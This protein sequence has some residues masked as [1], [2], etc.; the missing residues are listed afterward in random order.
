MPTGT[1]GGVG[2]L[3]A[4]TKGH[5]VDTKEQVEAVGKIDNSHKPQDV[6]QKEHSGQELS[7]PANIDEVTDNFETLSERVREVEKFVQHS[8]RDLRFDVDEQ[9]GDMVVKVYDSKTDELIREIP[10]DEMMHVKKTQALIG[11][12]L[13]NIK[14]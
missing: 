10:S 13:L 8:Q 14:V 3:Y 9:T 6:T 2:K 4:T 11:G 12:M 5:V 1:T 7:K